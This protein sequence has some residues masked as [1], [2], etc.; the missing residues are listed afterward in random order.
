MKPE[1]KDRWIRI[2]CEFSRLHGVQPS[3]YSPSG[4]TLSGEKAYK[5]AGSVD[6]WKG[7]LG[8]NLVCVKTFHLLGSGTE[9]IKQVCHGPPLGRGVG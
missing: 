5:T 6:V 7:K 4:V 9:G 8:E 2:L 1:S 3:S